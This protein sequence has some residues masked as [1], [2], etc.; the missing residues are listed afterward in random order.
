MV[1]AVSACET[2]VSFYQTTRRN[3]PE[4][5]FFILAAMRWNLT[6]VKDSDKYTLIP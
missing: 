1:E 4:E 5:V 3:I 6:K 2:S